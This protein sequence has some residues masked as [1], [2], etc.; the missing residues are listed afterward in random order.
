MEYI[1]SSG[2]GIYNPVSSAIIPKIHVARIPKRIPPL[3]LR[4]NKTAVII[5]PIIARTAPTPS[6][7]K[8]TVKSRS[9]INVAPSSTVILALINPIIAMNKPIPPLTATLRLA[10]MALKIASRTLVT[11]SNM[12]IIPSNPITQLAVR[13]LLRQCIIVESL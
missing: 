11:E 2:F 3:T 4:T 7:R 12:K 1:P 10:G 13:N 5:T 6:E 9:A 8:L